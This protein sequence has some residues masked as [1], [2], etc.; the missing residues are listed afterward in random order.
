MDSGP[1]IIQYLSTAARIYRE[2]TMIAKI[3]NRSRIREV[4]AMK[5][6]GIV[7]LTPS[8]KSNSFSVSLELFSVRLAW[9]VLLLFFSFLYS[10]Y[11]FI[12]TLK[13][14][15]STKYSKATFIN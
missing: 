11:L 1:L 14:I 5:M 7:L 8:M 10:S 12:K 6:R 4:K 15:L 2:M 3:A 13:T 9:R